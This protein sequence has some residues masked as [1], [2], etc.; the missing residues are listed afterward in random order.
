[1]FNRLKEIYQE[2]ENHTD[3]TYKA[4]PFYTKAIRDIKVELLKI[5]TMQ[6]EQLSRNVTDATRLIHL[7]NRDDLSGIENY[8][9]E[10]PKYL[11][12]VRDTIISCLAFVKKMN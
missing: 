5:A 12:R 10:I 1:M 11:K 2:V 6:G 9:K 4:I 8:P 3:L 7:T